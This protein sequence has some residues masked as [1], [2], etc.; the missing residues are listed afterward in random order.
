MT[1]HH[2]LCASRDNDVDGMRKAIA[3]GAYLETR[4]PF[5]MRPK[6]TAWGLEARQQKK[7]T[8]REG[9]TPLMYAVQTGSLD[10]AR[11]LLEAKAQ[12][13]ARDEDGLGPL[14]F[15]AL[16]GTPE[17]CGLLISHGADVDLADEEGLTAIDYVP[18]SCLASRAE[19]LRWEVHLGPAPGK[20][21]S[22][23]RT[24]SL[25]APVQA[26][27]NP[28]GGFA[29]PVQFEIDP[30]DGR[31]GLVK[32]APN[33]MERD[34]SRASLPELLATAKKDY[35]VV[36]V[37]S[38]SVAEAPVIE[39]P[40]NLLG[41]PV[42]SALPVAGNG[43]ACFNDDLIDQLRKTDPTSLPEEASA[44]KAAAD[45]MDGLS[46]DL[47]TPVLL[48]SSDTSAEE[49]PAAEDGKALDAH[50][51]ND[52]AP[53]QS[54]SAYPMDDLAAPPTAEAPAAKVT[55]DLIDGPVAFALR[56]ETEAS[57]GKV[58]AD[59]MD[60]GAPPMLPRAAIACS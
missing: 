21:P 16:E 11:L 54:W 15:A 57:V 36:P 45:P 5:V 37:K 53:L 47:V 25:P 17:V 44:E 32:V 49:A 38:Q 40:D 6:P 58:P 51:D 48:S 59:L 13:N 19:R 2:L 56:S 34:D 46:V 24:N 22:Q 41:G 31:I 33:L 26:E 50:I 1:N 14:H 23:S 55:D 12:V 60:L 52:I 29:A 7:K 30:L 35:H 20:L 27:A 39:V 9:L 10:G 43:W 4:R 18:K 8:Q 3:E 42:A 28:I